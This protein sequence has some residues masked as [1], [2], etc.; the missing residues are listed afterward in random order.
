MVP[1]GGRNVT[2]DIA[3][4]LRTSVGQAEEMK[5]AFG[6]ALASAVDPTEMID[7]PAVAGR[8]GKTISRNVLASIIEPRMEEIFSLVNRGLKTVHRLDMFTSGLVL[9]GG[10]S[11]LNGSLELAEQIFDMPD[12]RGSLRRIKHTPEELDGGRYSSAHGLLVYGFENEP[13]DVYSGGIL[14]GFLK[15]VEQW[16]TKRL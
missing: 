6:A 9:T 10:G 8:A 13:V 11:I 4:G 2:N 16:I 5:L 14:G 15:K 7:V 12:R 3:I 1:L